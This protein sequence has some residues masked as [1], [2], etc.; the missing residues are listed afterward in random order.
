MREQMLLDYLNQEKIKIYDDCSKLE[1]ISVSGEWVFV[2][3]RSQCG[4]YKD[5]HTLE[6]ID[7]VAW[8]YSK[9]GSQGDT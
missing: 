2:T 8:V 6:L 3:E 1:N 9:T 7:V 4:Y 5:T